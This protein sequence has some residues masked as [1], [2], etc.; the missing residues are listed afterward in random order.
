MIRT[1]HGSSEENASIKFGRWLFNVLP[2]YHNILK[3]P[4]DD[5]DP[6][7]PSDAIWSALAQVMAWRRQCW[8]IVNTVPWLSSEGII[9]RYEDIN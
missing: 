6:L 3:I 4:F 9:R 2:L 8:L 5:F 1:A 7:W